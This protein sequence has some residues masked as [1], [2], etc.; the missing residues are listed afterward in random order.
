MTFKQFASTSLADVYFLKHLQIATKQL[1]K[2]SLHFA[3]TDEVAIN[4]LNIEQPL[5][6]QL[7]IYFLQTLAQQI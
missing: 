7:L 5:A 1:L 2:C 4:F 3:D 6:Q